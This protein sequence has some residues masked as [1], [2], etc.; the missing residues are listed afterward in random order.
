MA[1]GEKEEDPVFC[2][3]DILPHLSYKVQDDRK[4]REVIKGEELKLLFGNTP[5]RWKYWKK[6]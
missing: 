4:A 5:V 2:I 6:S 1:I 3:P